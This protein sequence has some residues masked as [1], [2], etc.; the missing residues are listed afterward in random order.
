MSSS[1]LCCVQE[2]ELARGEAERMAELAD[3]ETQRC[4]AL[5][6]EMVERME[7]SGG[8]GGLLTQQALADK[9]R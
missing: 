2:A 6:R 7:E 4:L 1:C 8:S 9:D 3:S 5:E